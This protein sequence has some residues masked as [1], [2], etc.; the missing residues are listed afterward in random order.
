MIRFLLHDLRGSMVNRSLWVFCA[1]LFLGIVLIAASSALLKLV[2]AGLDN[3]SRELFGGDVQLSTRAP[4]DPAQRAWLDASGQVSLLTELR[5]MLGTADGAFTVIE[6]QSVD[7]A[8]PLYGQVVLDPPISLD[9]AVQ[10]DADGVWGAAF[11]PA[12]AVELEVAA[13]DRVTLG[14]LDV[15]LRAAIAE[16]PDR[17]L[18]ADVSGPPIIVDQEAL[19]LSGLAGP[20]S[21]VDFDYR[22]K[23]ADV[24]TNDWRD[25]LRTAFPDADWEVRTV[26]ERGEFVGERLDQVAAVLLLI[27]FATLLIGGL[28]VANGMRAYLDIKRPT[29]ATLQSLGARR[30]Q[31]VQVFVGQ[32]V[33]I[34]AASAGAGAVAGAAIAWQV[35]RLLGERLPIDASVGDL[36][37][38][39]GLVWLFGILAALTFALPSLGQALG[40]RPAQ[41]LR[42]LQLDSERG[43][44]SRGFMTATLL[45]GACTAALLLLLV[46]QPAIGIA[47]VLVAL[48]LYGSLQLIARLIEGAAGRAARSDALQHR[49][50][51]RHAVGGLARPGSALRPM[52]LSLGIA[53]TVLCASALVITSLN[54]TL[55]DSIPT[56][57]PALVF[58]DIQDIELDDFQAT[59]DALESIDELVTAPL[60]LG[61]LQAVNGEILADS[62]DSERAFEAN[63]EHKLSRRVSGIDSTTVTRGAWWPDDYTGPPLVAMEDREADQLGLEV[64]DRLQFSIQGQ[65]L[66]VTLAGI[67]E[68]ATLESRFWFEAVFSPGVI[69]PYVTRHV[70]SAWLRDDAAAQADIEAMNAIGR[71]FP[72]VVSIRTARALDTARSILGAASLAVTLVAIVSLIA[73]VLVMASVIAVNRHR[74]TYEATILHAVGARMGRLIRATLLEYALMGVVVVVFAALIG[75]G[76][77]HLLMSTWIDLPSRGSR[78]AAPLTALVATTLCLGSATAWLAFSLRATPARLLR[79]AG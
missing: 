68:Q 21:V 6:L 11:D 4:V 58:Y 55:F 22:L 29:L 46:P 64:G 44:M 23:L 30:R 52:L 45:C 33:L 12:L 67:Y 76:L 25:A 61:R 71:E 38:P 20:M 62:T 18:R 35:A 48:L 36:L 41:L 26:E 32:T 56:R 47:F 79:G 7:A 1:S 74:H 63:D 57:A 72:T 78:I 31:S 65:A 14:G 42:G 39:T 16:Q 69:E 24:E 70:G 49:F 10:R 54:R 60:V 59:V 40:R 66:D 51:W 19:R 2:Q 13:G 28:G 50:V 75:G 5:T 9:E 17:S 34:A 8:Y 53:L 27:G 43:P 77:G 37:A 15:Q 73:S 3:R